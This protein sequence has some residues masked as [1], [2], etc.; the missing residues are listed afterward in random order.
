MK[1]LFLTVSVGGGH[2]KA[3]QNLA[4]YL[5]SNYDNVQCLIMDTL[6]EINPL[7]D[8]VVVGSY[9]GTLKTS[10]KLY[11]KLFNITDHTN[12]FS[13]LS[14]QVNKILSIRLNTMIQNI[15]PD[16]IFCTHPFPIEMLSIL[17][18]KNKID[19]PIIAIITDYGIHSYWVYPHID[20]YIIAHES[21]TYDLNQKGIEE[22]KILPLGLPVSEVFS[23][24]HNK[25]VYLETLGLKNKPTILIMGGSLG[26]GDISNVFETLLTSLTG[27]QIVVIC[28]TNFKLYNNLKIYESRNSDVKVIGYTDKIALYMAAA[29]ILLTKPGGMTISEALNIGIP[30][31]LMSPIPGQEER[32]A[33]FLLNHGA[34]ISLNSNDNFVSTLNQ[35]LD[36]PIRLKSMKEMAKSIAKPNSQADISKCI[37]DAGK[38]YIESHKE[39]DLY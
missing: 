12:S 17:K 3:A 36:N 5:E 18:G 13:D 20:K 38:L 35:L 33:R 39:H 16:V 24:P 1:I 31:A 37:Y 8:K 34:A 22:S 10:P 9:L 28:G 21:L 2:N 27:F 4:N 30:M 11:G 32:N 23:K 26:F 14:R 25:E 19:M 15:K 7:V 29:D 6:R